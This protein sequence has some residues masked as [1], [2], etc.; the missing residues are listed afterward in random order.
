MVI[1][2]L[3]LSWVARADAVAGQPARSAAEVTAIGL[4][5][6]ALADE[7]HVPPEALAVRRISSIEWRDSSLGCPQRGRIYSPVVI[8]GHRVGLVHDGREYDVHVGAG[9]ALVCGTLVADPKVSTEA[10]LGPAKRA[11]DKVRDAVAARARVPSSAVRVDRSRPFRAGTTSCPGA[12]RE[13]RGPAFIVEA[14]AADASFVYYTDDAVTVSCDA[15][16]AR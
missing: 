6:R 8:A 10:V 16:T 5:T 14:R 7:L 12:P 1:V 11:S 3:A 4:A 2:V 13:A 15:P 9:R